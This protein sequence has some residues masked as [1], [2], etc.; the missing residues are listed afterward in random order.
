ML[1]DTAME[2]A[3]IAV[4]EGEQEVGEFETRVRERGTFLARF[5]V[6]FASKPVTS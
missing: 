2:L 1:E 4:D 3:N 6:S 5:I